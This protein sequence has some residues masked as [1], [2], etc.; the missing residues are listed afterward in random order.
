MFMKE[1]TSDRLVEG[2]AR[3]T[4]PSASPTTEGRSVL[5]YGR[6]SSYR[7]AAAPRRYAAP[8][9]IGLL[10]DYVARCER[11]A[12]PVLLV[13]RVRSSERW[14]SGRAV[15]RV[16]QYEAVDRRPRAGQFREPTVGQSRERLHV[17][18]RG[19]VVN[20]RLGEALRL[21]RQPGIDAEIEPGVGP[22]T[23]D[24]VADRTSSQYR[25]GSNW[26]VTRRTRGATAGS[27][28]PVAAVAGQPSQQ[29]ERVR[30]RYAQVRRS[31]QHEAT[32]SRSHQ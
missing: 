9:R 18:H 7:A 8:V 31:Q 15:R 14:R 21:L 5:R 17:Y 26:A 12:E 11:R 30:V 25:T 3:S 28:C 32:S 16:E 19:Q 20:G 27:R 2:A 24:D 1:P 23:Q 13:G 29:R 6:R 10:P 4:S 22:E